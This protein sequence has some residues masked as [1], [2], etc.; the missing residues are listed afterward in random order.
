MFDKIARI[1]QRY[2]DLEKRMIDPEVL[3]DHIK[4]TELAQE[5][6]DLQPLVESYRRHGELK[7]ELA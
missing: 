4:L 1:A 7:R 6:S 5:R 2:E 3:A